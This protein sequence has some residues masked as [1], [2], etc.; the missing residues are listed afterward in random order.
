MDFLLSYRIS[1]FLL[2]SR[3]IYQSVVADY[4]KAIWPIQIVCLF[5]SA[6]L[7]FL[8][9]RPSASR[10]RV[11]SVLLSII[12]A[13]IGWIFHLNHFVPINWAARY[14]AWLFFIQSALFLVAAAFGGVSHRHRKHA[15]WI[16]G[17]CFFVISAF[18]PVD[19]LKGSPLDEIALF[20][21]G[22][23]MTSVGTLGLLL[24]RKG[25]RW[26]QTWLFIGPL[27]YI[28]IA[29]LMRAGWS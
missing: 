27:L 18:I 5:I 11:V 14:F 15:A 17:I 9:L 23:E 8:S 16:I 13:G 7:I 1:D 10:E 25:V 28:V 2:F 21:W 29:L 3:E 6:V 24:M 20:G 12:W 4:N 22:A 26:L 19:M